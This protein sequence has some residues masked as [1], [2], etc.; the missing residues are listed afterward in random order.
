MQ[1]GSYLTDLTDTVPQA[2]SSLFIGWDNVAILLVGVAALYY[3]AAFYF[4]L[5]SWLLGLLFKVG[6]RRLGRRVAA[7]VSYRRQDG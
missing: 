4:R 1:E 3:L 2:A 5:T 7:P 6:G